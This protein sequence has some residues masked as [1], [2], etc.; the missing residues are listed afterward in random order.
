MRVVKLIEDK[1]SMD[2]LL[3]AIKKKDE[4]AFILCVI[5][6]YTGARYSELRVRTVQ[7]L[8][9]NYLRLGSDLY[10]GTGRNVRI[11]SGWKPLLE[12]YISSCS[13]LQK[14]V[15]EKEDGTHYTLIE[16][17]RIV[18][19]AANKLKLNGV[20]FASFRKTFGHRLY[21]VAKK[22][23]NMEKA[24][25]ARWVGYKPKTVINARVLFETATS[26]WKY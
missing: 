20:T 8:Q 16:M 15:T 5:S 19:A 21:R 17:N 9:G 24:E 26:K 6:A 18:V 2:K 25:F 23:T 10:N 14:K 22:K 7:D 4:Q 12:P 13:D 1:S 11:H 3:R